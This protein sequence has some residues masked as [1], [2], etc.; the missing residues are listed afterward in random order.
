ML[1]SIIPQRKIYHY[2][3]Q[4][5]ISYQ[6]LGSRKLQWSKIHRF[7]NVHNVHNMDGICSY[8]LWHREHLRGKVLTRLLIR[9]MSNSWERVYILN[10]AETFYSMFHVIINQIYIVWSKPFL[11]PNNYPV[12]FHIFEWIRNFI[13]HVHAKSLHN[14]LP[15]RY[16]T[17]VCI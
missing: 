12:Y 13:L 2:K 4:K 14:C 9:V 15:G 3:V 6:L 5:I 10:E 7:Y 11:G 17:K 1:M 16:I 8:L